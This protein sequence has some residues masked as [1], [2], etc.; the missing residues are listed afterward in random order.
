MKG[1]FMSAKPMWAL[2]C[3]NALDL[4]HG[5]LFQGPGVNLEAKGRSGIE[6][7]NFQARR[8]GFLLENSPVFQYGTFIIIT[9]S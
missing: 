6:P 7:P 9:V 8:C 4:Y 1:F 5:G 3:Q 2:P